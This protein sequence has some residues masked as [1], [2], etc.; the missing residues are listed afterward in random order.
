MNKQ[1][2]FFLLIMLALSCLLFGCASKKGTKVIGVETDSSSVKTEYEYGEELSVDGLVVYEVYS[3]GKKAETTAYEVSSAYDK[4]AA[5]TY[6]VIISLTGRELTDSFFVTVKEAG[7]CGIETDTENAVTEFSYGQEFSAEGLKVYEVYLDGRKTLTDDYVLT[8]SYDAG[9]PGTYEITVTLKNAEYSD[10]YSVTVNE[11]DAEEGVKIL[12]IGNSYSEDATK[13]L[14]QI[15]KD[16]GVKNATVGH[17]FIGGTSIQDHAANARGDKPVYQYLV[18]SDGDFTSQSNITLAEGIAAED[19]DIVTLQQL[20]ATSG[21]V[22]SYDDDI[23]YLAGY[24]RSN[25]TNP[26]VRLAWHM[27]WSWPGYATQS[28]FADYYQSSQSVM[29]GMITAAVEEKIATSSLFD[30]IIPS[31]TAIQNARTSFLGDTLNRDNYHLSLNVGRYVAGMTYAA[32]LTGLSFE[33][34]QYVPSAAEIDGYVLNIVKES[35]DNALKKP[36]EV[37]DSEY[38][39]IAEA[40]TDHKK[41]NWMPVVSGYWESTTSANFLYG[42]S[43]SVSLVASSKK[44]TKETLPVNSVITIAAGFKYRPEG[45]V[46][47]EVQT[48]RPDYVTTFYLRVTEDWW[49]NYNTRAFN[50]MNLEFSSLV[51]DFDAAVAALNIYVPTGTPQL[52]GYDFDDTETLAAAG[53]DISDY[54]YYDWTPVCGWLNSVNSGKKINSG[55]AL[56]QKYI[57]SKWME[58]DALPAGTLLVLDGGYSIRPEGYFSGMTSS[59]RP[60]PITN[61]TAL[62]K[63]I[64]VTADWWTKY[65]YRAIQLYYNTAAVFNNDIYYEKCHLRVYLPK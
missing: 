57:V 20:S 46:T 48:S 31:G 54:D 3:N 39:D 65:S 14:W 60:A 59:D 22:S 61:T 63:I 58:E 37:T 52:D 4:N 34:V 35:V 36:F 11:F 38:H 47:E 19:W 2:T 43:V 16:M 23:A 25:A 30:M 53:Y 1:L 29:Y 33:N 41:I 10:K 15:L 7:T 32:T 17:L 55:D 50:V 51:N 28:E 8:H 13:W 5:G 40:L 12:A 27:N 9:A 64:T 6:E 21:L 62:P 24:V 56:S 42:R 18:N 44:F 26:Y 45:W 49:A